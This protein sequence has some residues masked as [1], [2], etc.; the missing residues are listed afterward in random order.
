MNP[1]APQRQP[2]PELALL[3]I[4]GSMFFVATVVESDA[5]F[6]ASIFLCVFAGFA[7]L[8]ST[9]LSRQS[10]RTIALLTILGLILTGIGAAF[11]VKD[12][13]EPVIFSLGLLIYPGGSLALSGVIN[14]VSRG[15]RRNDS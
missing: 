7:A 10:R 12:A 3:L 8:I 6:I 11:M 9:W 2:A 1:D 4:G 15:L 14:L 5:L 13:S